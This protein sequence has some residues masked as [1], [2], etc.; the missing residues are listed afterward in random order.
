MQHAFRKDLSHLR[1]EEVYARQ[2]LRAPLVGQWM[3]ALALQS[4]DRVLDV[5]AGPGY[6]SLQLA[7]RVGAKGL[8]Y[9][10]DRSA[11]ALAYLANLQEQ[12]GVRQ[13]DRIVAD[14]SIFEPTE[15]QA[16]KALISMVLHHAD[17]PAAIVRNIK[18]CL[19]PG[20]SIVIAEFH[21]DGPCSG[22]PPREHRLAPEQITRWCEEARLTVLKFSRQSAEHY[23]LA[24]EKRSR[25]R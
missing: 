14:A 9:A 18:R 22:G 3:D 11:D 5:G 19:L 12:A 23:M 1:W 24:A 25:D 7:E 21:P 8:V 16:Q 17:D 4:G 20:A 6:V 2:Q 15:L 10:L 13:I